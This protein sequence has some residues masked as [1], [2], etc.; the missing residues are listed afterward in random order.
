[1]DIKCRCGKQFSA[2]RELLEHLKAAKTLLFWSVCCG[3]L[4]QETATRKFREEHSI[5][6]E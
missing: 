4:D 3:A 5:V 2:L 1:M 6:E